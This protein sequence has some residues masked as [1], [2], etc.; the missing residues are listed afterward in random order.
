MKK[1]LAFAS[2][3]WF[4]AI[5][6]PSI[7]G[8]RE[9]DSMAHAMGNLFPYIGIPYSNLDAKEKRQ[10]K[11]SLIRE[12]DSIRKVGTGV[13][14]NVAPVV[15]VVAP[16]AKKGAGAAAS[17]AV[18]AVGGAMGGYFGCE[19]SRTC[20]EGFHDLGQLINADSWFNW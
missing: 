7:A 20:S 14:E 5:P 16:A 15:V 6:V 9:K 4:L 11:K 12:L 3:F 17:G 18:G 19:A 8:E 10:F 2:I 1:L 13:A